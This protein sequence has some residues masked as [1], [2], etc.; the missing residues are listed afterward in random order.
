MSGVIYREA[1]YFVLFGIAFCP[2][3]EQ[4]A[5]ASENGYF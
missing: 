4:I 1:L 3:P 2:A 5:C